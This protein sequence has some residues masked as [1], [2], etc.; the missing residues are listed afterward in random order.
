MKSL[1]DSGDEDLFFPKLM[2]KSALGRREAR[3]DVV[4]VLWDDDDAA[5]VGGGSKMA[6]GRRARR[7]ERTETAPSEGKPYRLIIAS[8]EDKWKTR[9]LGFP[10]W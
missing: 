8:S 10:G 6:S 1:I 9:G 7:R 3:V 2:A 5:A 4:L